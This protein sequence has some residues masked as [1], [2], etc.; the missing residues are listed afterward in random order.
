MLLN[1]RNKCKKCRYFLSIKKIIF[2]NL[3]KYNLL[4]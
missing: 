1:Y 3:N 4:N 2:K